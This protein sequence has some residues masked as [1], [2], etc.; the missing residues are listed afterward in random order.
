M[1]IVSDSPTS[2]DVIQLQGSTGISPV[3]QTSNLSLS[4]TQLNFPSN[5][6]ATGTPQTVVMTDTGK[7]PLV[8]GSINFTGSGA[9]DFL[10]TDDCAGSV[11][12]NGSCTVEVMIA[13]VNS[14]SSAQMQI[15][16]DDTASPALV[17][18]NL[19]VPSSTSLGESTSEL[20]FSTQ[21]TPQPYASDPQSVTFTNTGQGSVTIS[22]T[23]I[24]NDPDGN[25]SIV[26]D[27]CSGATVAP[28]ASCVVSVTYTDYDPRASGTLVIN[29][30][31]T[32]Q[33][34]P[35]ALVG[36]NG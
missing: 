33:P 7:N 11:D 15:V 31:E 2:P 22:S 6:L 1:Q 24:G 4:T 5:A 13:N 19:N 26:G 14:T 27:S 36:V 30:N 20:D 8:I 29:S 32:N 18:I 3:V 16:T 9:G 34:Q 25:F 21:E 23:S 12:V 10:E 17:Q 28:G 35:V